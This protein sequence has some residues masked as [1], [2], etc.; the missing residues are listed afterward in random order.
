MGTSVLPPAC[1]AARPGSIVWGGS[2]AKPAQQRCLQDHSVLKADAGVVCR[3]WRVMLR[4][5][6][7]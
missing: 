6:A 2:H 3:G 1:A 4:Q 5:P 7:T